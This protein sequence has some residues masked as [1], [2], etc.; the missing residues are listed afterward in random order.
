MGNARGSSY[1]RNHTTL[2]PDTDSKFWNFSWHEI[3]IYDLPASI[4]YILEVTN[5]NSLY[6]V[7]HSQGSTSM[8]VMASELPE[9]NT[10]IKYYAHLA[11]IAFM[12]HL[13]SPPFKILAG[14]Q[15]VVPVS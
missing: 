2:N 11:P 6:Y 9:Y 13:V 8:Y 7:G 15:A 10:K 4:D 3:G 14:L 12:G 5:S 1:S